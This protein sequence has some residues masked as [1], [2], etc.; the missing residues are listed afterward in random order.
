[1]AGGL[2]LTAIGTTTDRAPAPKPVV[3]PAPIARADAAKA[4]AKLPTAFEPKGGGYLA[5]GSGYDVFLDSRGA[6]LALQHGE[7]RRPTILRSALAGARRVTPVSESRLPGVINEYGGPRSSWR[8]GIPTFAKV[9]YPSVYPGVDAVYHGRNGQLEYDFN[10]APGANPRSIAMR[11]SGARSLRIARNGD[12]VVALPHGTIR[13]TQPVAY[14]R[15]GGQRVPIDVR[16]R[17]NGARVGFVVGRYDRALPL[18]I[19]PVLSYA[20]YFGGSNSDV[21]TSVGVGSDGSMF[22]AG[23]TYSS[24]LPGYPGPRVYVDEDALVTRIAADGTS[25]IYTTLLGNSVAVSGWTDAYADD[26]INDMLVSGQTAILVGAAKSQGY[27]RSS[28]APED[29]L[30]ACNT[31]GQ[32]GVW[33]FLTASGTLGYSTCFGGTGDD[34]AEAITARY[35]GGIN[36]RTYYAIVGKSTS[37][38]LPGGA[39]I[40]G[41]QNTSG[42][43]RDGFLMQIASDNSGVC[44]NDPSPCIFVHYRTYI[45]GGSDDSAYGVG[46]DS[47]GY[48]VVDGVTGSSNFPVSSGSPL[49]GN[50]DAWIAKFGVSGTTNVRSFSVRYGGDGEDSARDL[51]LDS[52]NNAYIVGTTASTNLPAVPA[53]GNLVRGGLDDGFIAKV[54]TSGSVANS[55]YVGGTRMDSLDKIAL[56]ENGSTVAEYAV[57]TTSSGPSDTFV[58]RN[59]VAGHSCVENDNDTQALV[60]KRIV[61]ANPEGAVIACLGGSSQNGDT[62]TAIAVPAA[63]TDGTMFVAGTTGGGFAGVSGVQTSFRGGIDGFLAVLE[64]P[65]PSIDSGPADGAIIS[66]NSPQFALSTNE[67][68]THMAC[69]APVAGALVAGPRGTA[70][71]PASTASYSGLVDG[72]HTFEATTIDPFGSESAAATRAFTVDTTPPDAFGLTAPGDGESVHTTQPTFSWSESHDTNGLSYAVVLDGQAIHTVAD[73]T[74][75]AGSCSAQATGPVVDGAHTVQV[76]ASDRATPANTRA[77]SPRNFTVVDPVQARFTIAPNP[78]LTG[79]T[80]SFDGSASADASH[81]ITKYEWDLDGDGTFETDTGTTPTTGRIFFGA[82]TFDIGLRVTGD[83]GGTTTATQALKVNDAPG[84]GAQIG[85]SINDGAQY[86]NDPKVKL[87]VVAPPGVTAL[88]ISND[89]GFAGALPQPV[90]NEID[91]TLD[92]SGPERLPKTVYLRFLTGPFA[93]PNYTDDIILDERP[94]VVDSAAI[95]GAPAAASSAAV[96]KARTWK[97]KVK[98]HDTNSGVGF[99]QVTASKK[100]PGRLLKYRKSVKAKSPTR[101]KFLRARDRAGNYSKWRKLR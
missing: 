43:F 71:C 79:R 80:V 29:Y 31:A 7:S 33:T 53:G 94:P 83:V 82:G 64:Q 59:T 3:E 57:G 76:V 95:A 37:G 70:D 10:V 100:R 45:G 41:Y 17:L 89:G 36:K 60:V 69:S 65:P 28:G 55:V 99:V 34:E 22:L 14:Q 8:S 24:S 87:K 68:G 39:T 98:A 16:Y 50:T 81:K 48:A 1:V 74:C 90:S 61:G 46:Y 6:T 2:A 97:V 19:D 27:P 49:G 62:G 67:L 21:I 25:V 12:L 5:R 13:Q 54:D 85:V 86:T 47:S 92:S 93:S 18:V 84:A 88:L 40:A 9:R 4:L 96:A 78:A 56:Q 20:T 101:P 15:I 66:S 32:N 38:D 51:A 52:S 26:Q 11:L 30:G 44:T 77:T 72:Q 63:A 75:S 73:P 23:G 35:V 58:P 42:G 91:W